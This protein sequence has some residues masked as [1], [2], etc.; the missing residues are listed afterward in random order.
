MASIR[1]RS[2]QSGGETKT[3][4]IADYF[5]QN[6][7]RHI[8]TFRTKTEARHWL[9]NTEV[10]VKAGEHVADRA[11]VTVAQAAESW[12]DTCRHGRPDDEN[13]GLEE[14]TVREYK[15]HVRYI[16]DPA[17]GI[18]QVKLNQL[19][20]ATVEAFLKRLRDAGRSAS[21][22]RKVRTSLSSLIGHAQE[23]GQVGRNVLRDD[24]RRRRGQREQPEITIP[25]KTELR[26]MQDDTKSPLWLRTF[27]AIAIYGGVRA[28]EIRGLPWANVDLDAGV[29]RVRQRANFAGRIGPPKSRAGNRDVPMVPRVRRLLSELFLAQGRPSDRLVFATSTGSAMNH[30]N[31]VQRFYD[32]LQVRL[33]IADPKLDQAGKP[34]MDEHGEPVMVARYGLHALR[35]AAA[36]LFIEQGMNPKR[37]QAIMGHSSITMTMDTYGHLF[38]DGNSD[39]AAMAQLEALLG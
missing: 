14:S 38:P 32:P 13:G 17:I 35:H 4:W 6:G 37:I 26:A 25:A 18:G 5:D 3:A 30:S 28:S 15:R 16:K 7:K 2:W 24:R 8:K 36:S 23:L 10:D 21:M 9:P 27:L 19:S 34:V 33:G 12:L 31:L 1:K 22:A 29:I 11:S 39:Q 20:K